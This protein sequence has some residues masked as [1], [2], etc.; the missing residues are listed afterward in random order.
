MFEISTWFVTIESL[1]DKNIARKSENVFLSYYRLYSFP[2]IFDIVHISFKMLV[3][4]NFFSCCLWKI[5]F[6]C[7]SFELVNRFSKFFFIQT[8][9]WMAGV[10]QDLL[11]N[12]NLYLLARFNG[13]CSSR[14]ELVSSK[15]E[16][17]KNSHLVGQV[18]ERQIS[19]Y[20][21]S[22]VQSFAE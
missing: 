9:F 6:V 3:I 17:I 5:S 14:I 22:Q 1:E 19:L 8:D 4:I 13:A 18:K 16:L 10:I 15:N 21:N 11:L 7:G 12:F 20:Q 2:G